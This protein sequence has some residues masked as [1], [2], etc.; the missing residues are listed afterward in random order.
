MS[1]S[2]DSPSPEAP[3]D[4]PASPAPSSRDASPAPLSL[5]GTPPPAGLAAALDSA[6]SLPIKAQAKLAGLLAPLLSALPDDQLDNRI[7]RLCGQEQLDAKQL[8]PPLKAAR[9]LF[10]HAAR[11]N[12]DADALA[13]DIGGLCSA[14]PLIIQL[15]LP[16]YVAALPVMRE[17]MIAASLQAHG[18]VLA[19]VEWRIDT[20][21]SSSRGRQ[22]NVPVAMVTFHYQ[23]REQPG[24]F[25]IQMLPSMVEELRNVCDE[26]LGT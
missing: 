9:F 5:G 19:N 6:A 17:E 18:R 20:I 25:T 21:G 23:D 11:Q 14:A 1:N 8:A 3:S 2:D 12:L 16:C 24:S 13:E 26:L 7:I 22:L 15:L 10:L 4:S